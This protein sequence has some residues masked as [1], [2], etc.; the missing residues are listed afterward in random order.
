MGFLSFGAHGPPLPCDGRTV[1]SADLQTHTVTWTCLGCPL[2]ESTE[3]AIGMSEDVK[4]AEGATPA[5]RL[6][7]DFGN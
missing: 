7:A 1:G 2:V 4:V 6:Y 3:R 5:W